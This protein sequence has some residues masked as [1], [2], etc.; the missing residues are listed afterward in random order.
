MII[1]TILQANN[2]EKPPCLTT[3]INKDL[4]DELVTFL[5]GDN[6]VHLTLPTGV[7]SEKAKYGAWA[8]MIT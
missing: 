6:K 4:V 5:A 7:V 2:M 8:L 1:T 3:P